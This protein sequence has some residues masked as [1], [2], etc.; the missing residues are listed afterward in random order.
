MPLT[1]CPLLEHKGIGKSDVKVMDG[2]V[3]Q[4]ERLKEEGRKAHLNA[5]HHHTIHVHEMF[6]NPR[7]QQ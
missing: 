3:R 7:Q 5:K 2:L 4:V 1:N 6:N